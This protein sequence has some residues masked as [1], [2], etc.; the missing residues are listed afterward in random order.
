VGWDRRFPVP[1]GGAVGIA[2]V[3]R[4][5]LRPARKNKMESQWLLRRQR[6][7]FE[8]VASLH[9]RKSFGMWS[10]INAGLEPSPILYTRLT[11]GTCALLMR[12][13]CGS[14]RSCTAGH[15]LVSMPLSEAH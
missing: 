9:E 7:S 14:N 13:P 4:S 2:I 3:S 12:G 5:T 8:K 1:G 6:E 11:S 10:L 15:S